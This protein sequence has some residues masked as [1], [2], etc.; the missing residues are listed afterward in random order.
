M[1]DEEECK[2]CV[3]RT[4]DIILTQIVQDS[5]KFFFLDRNKPKRE[6]PR[7]WTDIKEKEDSNNG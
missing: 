5:I 6:T 4:R 2:D 7:Y 1:V 3:H